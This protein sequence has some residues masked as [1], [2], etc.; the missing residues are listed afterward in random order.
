[1]DSAL[2]KSNDVFVQALSLSKFA[3]H[4]RPAAEVALASI[5]LKR[6]LMM[7]MA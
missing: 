2:A 3:G 1:M 6:L 5:S 7:K 4:R